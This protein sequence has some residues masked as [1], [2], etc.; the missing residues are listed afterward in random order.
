MRGREAGKEGGR[1]RKGMKNERSN[2][3]PNLSTELHL[4]ENDRVK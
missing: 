2:L 3:D 1:G 4:T